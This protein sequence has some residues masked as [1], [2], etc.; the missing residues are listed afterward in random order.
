LKFA[1]IEAKY[2]LE[3]RKYFPKG[4]ERKDEPEAGRNQ[5]PLKRK[6]E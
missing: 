1:K 3:S 4:K 2:E 6:A 5:K